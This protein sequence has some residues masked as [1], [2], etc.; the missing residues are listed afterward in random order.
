PS[1]TVR[2]ESAHVVRALCTLSRA[3][4]IDHLIALAKAGSAGPFADPSLYFYGLNARQWLFIALARAAKDSR[5]ALARHADF[6]VQSALAGEVHVLIRGFAASAALA[7][8][9]HGLQPSDPDLPRRLASVNVSA[10]PPIQSKR[11]GGSWAE[12]G[13]RK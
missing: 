7:L 9:E 4:A 12:G 8:F 6:I 3:A 5:D 2:W 13:A 11:H 1:S 10:L